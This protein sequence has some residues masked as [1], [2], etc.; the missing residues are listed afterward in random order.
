[1]AR[2]TLIYRRGDLRIESRGDCVAYTD[3]NYG[4]DADGNRGISADFIEDVTVDE[5]DIFISFRN[6][7]IDYE[8][9]RPEN[10]KRVREWLEETDDV[11]VDP[12]DGGYEDDGYYEDSEY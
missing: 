2:C 10:K 1:M 9:L 6:K 11:A 8:K 5:E 4:A 7:D 3:H 12:Y